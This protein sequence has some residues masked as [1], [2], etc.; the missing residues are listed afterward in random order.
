MFRIISVV[1]FLAKHNLVFR[2][3]NAKLY[4]NN[5]ENFLGLIEMLVEFD[6]VIKEHVDRI[7]NDDIHFHYLG[8]NIQ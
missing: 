1:K 3:T 6:L 8:H 2:G 5:N 7:I 4:E